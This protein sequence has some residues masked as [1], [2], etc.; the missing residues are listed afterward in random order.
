M[1]MSLMQVQGV[2]KRFG[3]NYAL[4]DISLDL[5]KGEVHA[6]VGENGA[7]KSTFIKVVTG[8]YAPDGGKLVWEG[9][10]IKISSPRKALELGI[11]AVHQ[12]HQ[13]IPSLSGLENLYLGHPYPK[14]M[15]RFGVDWKRMK[16]EAQCL[17]EQWGIRVSLEN[18]AAEMSPSQQTFL[19]ILRSLRSKCKLLFLDEPTAALTDR[20]TESLFHLINNL[21][22]RGT[23]VIY[24]SH[25]LDEIFRLADRITVLRNGE[26]L[27]LWEKKR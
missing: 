26:R 27:A 23:S 15:A 11:C 6:L 20:E 7:G 8:L 14:R 13:L 9:K 12:D 3:D 1:S 21:K 4:A 18:T 5:K 2:Q 19:E 22:N 25:R 16:I 10:E 17:E 24:V